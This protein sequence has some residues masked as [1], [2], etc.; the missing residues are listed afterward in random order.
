MAAETLGIN[1]ER[2]KT[3]VFVISAVYASIGGSLYAH[4]LTH[5]DPGPFSLWSAFIFVIM[6]V[7]GGARSIWGP[8][9]GSAFYIGLKE[10]ISQVVPAT[11]SAALAGYQV[12]L[13]SLV[14]IM[15]LLFFPEGL[16]QVPAV[17]SQ[18]WVKRQGKSM[19]ESFGH[20]RTDG[21]SIF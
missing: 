12:V 21:Q 16:V 19:P 14:F 6:V 4:Y 11:H 10:L 15:V 8:I 7:I 5:L 2:M 13:F 18:R 9:I 3:Q 1:I 17:L 20:D